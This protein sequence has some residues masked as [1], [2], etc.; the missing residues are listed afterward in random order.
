L[1]SE[2][3]HAPSLTHGD[4]GDQGESGFFC[5]IGSERVTRTDMLNNEIPLWYQ[6]S[7]SLRAEITARRGDGSLRLPTEIQIAGQYGVSIITVRRALKSLEADG[8]ISRQRRNG[9]FINPEAIPKRPLKLLG[10]AESVFS[11]QA[12]EESELLEKKRVSAPKELMLFRRLRKD[13]DS[14]VSYAINHVL[15]EYGKRITREQV[16]T[17]PITQILRDDLGVR[18]TRIEDTVEARLAT[19]EVAQILQMD[20]M[21]PVLF[22]TGVTFDDKN[23]VVDI[24]YIHYRG[25]R[26]KFTVDFDVVAG[27]P[28]S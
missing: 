6:I 3:E 22:F 4:R 10:A 27:Y 5:L 25:D 18:I 17:K 23:S 28:G 21:T 26:F 12:S 13:H 20:I 11:Q 7:Q 14:P 15:P 9:T 24:A 19:P 2:A 16:L 1:I 8:L